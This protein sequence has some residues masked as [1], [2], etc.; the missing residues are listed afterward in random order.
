MDLEK[1]LKEIE[2]LGNNHIGSSRETPLRED[3]F[4]LSDIEK[5][6]LIKEDVTN[7]MTTLGLDLTD[8]SLKGTPTRVAKM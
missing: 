4:D 7:I 1:Q 5:I 2:A 8:D 3:A 6:K